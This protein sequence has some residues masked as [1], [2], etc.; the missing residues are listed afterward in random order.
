[1]MTITTKTIWKRLIFRSERETQDEDEEDDNEE[2][3]IF[4]DDDEQEA[5]ADYIKG[6]KNLGLSKKKFHVFFLVFGFFC[7]FYC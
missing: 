4:S 2:D 1:M 7:H 3:P 6:K 5:L